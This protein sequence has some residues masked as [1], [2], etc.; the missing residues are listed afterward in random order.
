MAP[1][2]LTNSDWLMP[3]PACGVEL[4]EDPSEHHPAVLLAELSCHGLTIEAFLCGSCL[5]YLCHDPSVIA[6]PDC[7]AV[8]D[9]ESVRL[10]DEREFE[11]FL[12]TA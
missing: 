6:C 9:I 5:D 7:G 12:R 2:T 1:I 11:T 3:V 4:D 10:I 8:P